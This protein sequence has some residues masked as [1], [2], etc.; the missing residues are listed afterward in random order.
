MN[1]LQ[2]EVVNLDRSD[3][4]QINFPGVDT[5]SQYE[6]SNLRYR[7]QSSKDLNLTNVLQFS[8][9]ISQS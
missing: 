8:D 9:E 6:V 5:S 7:P 2:Y 3:K 1:Y 4:S